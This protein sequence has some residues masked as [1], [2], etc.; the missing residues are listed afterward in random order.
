MQG[1]LSFLAALAFYAAQPGMMVLRPMI[2]L[3]GMSHLLLEMVMVL[4]IGG[5]KWVRAP[6][7]SHRQETFGWVQWPSC[8]WDDGGVGCFLSFGSGAG[9]WL[10]AGH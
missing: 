7:C 3:V 6:T 1:F 10:T 5:S 4:A 9:M 8:R 2:A